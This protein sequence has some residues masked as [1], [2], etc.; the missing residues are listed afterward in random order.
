[1]LPEVPAPVTM[2]FRF[3]AR[4]RIFSRP[5]QDLKITRWNVINQAFATPLLL[6]IFGKLRGFGART[7]KP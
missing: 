1:M 2:P 3:A 5:P 7:Y 4:L 6:L